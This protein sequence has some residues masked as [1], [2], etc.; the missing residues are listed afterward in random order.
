MSE[1]AKKTVISFT[2]L[3]DLRHIDR[4][5]VFSETNGTIDEYIV[6]IN[7]IRDKFKD[8]DPTYLIEDWTDNFIASLAIRIQKDRYVV[9]NRVEKYYV[10]AF[11]LDYTRCEV[12]S[13]DYYK[14]LIK[15]REGDKDDCIV[16]SIRDPDDDE[17]DDIIR[18]M[19][20]VHQK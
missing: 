19:K 8:N 6:F 13:K 12:F 14:E 17:Q 16:E 18:Y 5:P 4:V 1:S 15:W 20:L 10:M 2:I 11:A 9:Y 7:T 3:N